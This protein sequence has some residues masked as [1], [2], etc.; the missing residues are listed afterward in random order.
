MVY[1]VRKHTHAYNRNDSSEYGVAYIA[2]DIILHRSIWL[3]IYNILS[4]CRPYKQ[5]ICIQNKKERTNSDQQHK[6]SNILKIS[7]KRTV[8]QRTLE[9][10][11]TLKF[12][13]ITF[14]FQ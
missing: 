4:Q 11:N 12:Y 14:L 2:R 3:V 1:V 8:E 13:E 7:Y 10:D 9:F 5:R 6:G